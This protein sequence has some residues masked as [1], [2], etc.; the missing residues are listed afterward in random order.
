M[1][2]KIFKLEIS[3]EKAIL[4]EKILINKQIQKIKNADCKLFNGHN[5]NWKYHSRLIRTNLDK[6]SS[7]I[8][9][10]NSDNRCYSAMFLLNYLI[11]LRE[12]MLHFEAISNL[13][14]EEWNK[15]VSKLNL[16]IFLNEIRNLLKNE[17]DNSEIIELF[18][19]QTDDHVI[20]TIRFLISDNGAA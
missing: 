10:Y 11:P 9:K 12:Y 15:V 7:L 13:N 5:K 14:N 2:S 4:D 6:L 20:E 8:D 3:E 18:G 17:N 16:E 1:K 19:N